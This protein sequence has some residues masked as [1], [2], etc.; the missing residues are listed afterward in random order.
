MLK[1]SKATKISSSKQPL[2]SETLPEGWSR[3]RFQQHISNILGWIPTEG[4]CLFC[5]GYFK[6]PLMVSEFP[7]PAAAKKE[8]TIITARGSSTVTAKGISILQKDV[9]VIQPG[10]IVNAD[11]AYIYRDEKTGQVNKIVLVGHVRLREAGKLIVADKG[12]LT[13]HPKTAVLKNLAYRSYNDKSYIPQ[14][15][16]FNAWGTAKQAT[17][18]I[19]QVMTLQHATYSTC[20][21]TS[22][23]CGLVPRH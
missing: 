17:R 18:D 10:R 16:P 9:V 6:E 7:H 21:P 11:K 14:F 20:D 3:Y 12:K 19:S 22:P 23:T 8:P 2:V 1:V 5:H 15:N 13:L 4:I